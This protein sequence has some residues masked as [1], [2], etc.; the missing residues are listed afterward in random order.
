MQEASA[1]ARVAAG[2]VGDFLEEFRAVGGVRGAQNHYTK[3]TSIF[4]RSNRRL[5]ADLGPEIL[6]QVRLLDEVEEISVWSNEYVAGLLL[7]YSLRDLLSR[8]LGEVEVRLRR[9][10]TGSKISLEVVV[11]GSHTT[12][13]K[14]DLVDL[15]PIQLGAAVGGGTPRV[16]EARVDGNKFGYTLDFEIQPPAT[17]PS[18]EVF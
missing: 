2:R 15:S 13:E 1:D 6:N 17:T 9:S 4:E 14:S 10:D 5:R 16:V 7:S 12:R 8:N 11:G 3:L 18:L